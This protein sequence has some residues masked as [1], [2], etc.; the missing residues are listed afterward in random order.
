M[1][2][3]HYIIMLALC[4]LLL[5]GC[6]E[7]RTE[8]VQVIFTPD[9]NSGPFIISTLEI[10]IEA[11]DPSVQLY[12]ILG[13]VEAS[14]NSLMYSG[15]FR[16]AEDT[17]VSVAV[18]K[19]GKKI[20]EAKALYAL[21]TPEAPGETCTASR[22]CSALTEVTITNSDCTTST[23]SCA[24]AEKCT[25]GN[26]NPAT[27][28][29]V[30]PVTC[31]RPYFSL[32]RTTATCTSAG[33]YWYYNACWSTPA[34]GGGGGGGGGSSN[35]APTVT[36]LSP[37]DGQSYKPGN[38]FII[39]ANASDS[40]GSVKRVEFWM[41]YSAGDVVNP[42]TKLGEDSETPYSLVLEN[43]FNQEGNYQL[44][45]I[46]YD[47]KNKQKAT[48]VITIKIT[49]SL[50]ILGALCASGSQCQ[51]GLCVAENDMRARCAAECS[52]LGT[53]CSNDDKAYNN[54]GICAHM[55]NAV[56]LPYVEC[57]SSNVAHIGSKYESPCLAS[58]TSVGD[59]CDT[60]AAGGFV[61]DGTCQADG[62]CKVNLAP[63]VTLNKPLNGSS[64][65]VNTTINVS[66][67]ANDPDGTISKVEFYIGHT[68]GQ[69]NGGGLITDT[70]YPYEISVT[71]SSVG[72]YTFSAK[73]YDALGA[74]TSSLTSYVT[75]AAVN[76]SVPSVSI[77]SPVEGASF[78]VGSSIPITVSAYD[79]DGT[80][81]WAKVQYLSGSNWVDI[82]I[83]YTNAYTYRF[84]WNNA[85]VGSQAIRAIVSDN[86]QAQS[87]VNRNVNVNPGTNH[88]PN[89]SI[90]SP[91]NNA[92]FSVGQSIT[93]TASATDVDNNLK[94]VTFDYEDRDG[95]RYVIGVDSSSPYS[96]IWNNPL[97]G[98]SGLRATARDTLG[99]S[100]VSG[101]VYVNVNTGNLPPV[102]SI[103][104]PSNGANI[105]EGSDVIIQVSASDANNNLKNV[106]LEYRYGSAV[107]SSM[108]VKSV[109]PYTWQFDD[110]Q[111]GVLSLRAT[112]RDT[113]GL[114]TVSGVV[115]V[116][117]NSGVNNPPTVSIT[118]PASNG[119]SV[120]VGSVLSYAGSISDD[121]P[122]LNV[123]WYIDRI[124]DN[125]AGALIKN[126][127]QA[128][129]PT[130]GSLTMTGVKMNPNN[131]PVNLTVVGATYYLWLRVYDGVNTVEKIRT[132]VLVSSSQTVSL[133]NPLDYSVFDEGYTIPL[134]ATASPTSQLTNIRL[135]VD[136]A[137]K[138]TG[139]SSPHTYSWTPSKGTYLIQ[140]KALF[141]VTE[142]TSDISG[143]VVEA[144]CGNNRCSASE[145]GCN[146]PADCGETCSQIEPG[147]L[148]IES[149]STSDDAI[150]DGNEPIKAVDFD[151][152]TYWSSTT[153]NSITLDLGYSQTVSETNMKF[154]K[155]YAYKVETSN[156]GTSW[157]SAVT[158]NANTGWVKS[159][160]NSRNAR[161]VRVTFTSGGSIILYEAEVWGQDNLN[162][163]E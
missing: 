137:L 81:S 99:L 52:S 59:P 26:C 139:T 34:T 69:S 54:D 151:E 42:E 110:A 117:V 124:G 14:L 19:D 148:F 45:A 93:I 17:T 88:A 152:S 144:V 71:P 95:T 22:V 89:V 47:N 33:G 106:T 31:G 126:T 1:G 97:E 15:P 40:D 58:E 50:L 61:A 27:P 80:I 18:F 24:S 163:A 4:A 100:T 136:G 85:P 20:G 162:T 73:A 127:T 107:W 77:S 142:K 102:V 5:T 12:Y 21:V 149:V 60:N 115:N 161:Y 92:N 122:S 74:N 158:G 128:P 132:F 62:T 138:S 90:T 87:S 111:P 135:F 98:K 84:T 108:G 96:V 76:N 41:K 156:D 64:V 103:T 131:Y 56:Q 143:I 133:T 129:G 121:N 160:F 57:V 32:C 66:A 63:T 9:P 150:Q 105:S 119:S 48:P 11:N 70:S 13:D 39:N 46:A 113:L 29:N 83:N 154:G 82:A 134:T 72:I 30:T 104:S 43:G 109:G 49:N 44:W 3:K 86:R 8:E 130:S 68:T 114:S 120:V 75:V 94:N 116:N 118:S 55:Y 125:Q 23:I 2:W 37:V 7:Q 112:A 6:T 140:A 53:M 123:L 35:K 67:T 78:T 79:S 147:L 25:N 65:T 38:K 10:A 157:S 145:D 36:L 155:N 16:I 91:V 159:T 51:S 153:P 28:I 101:V 146:C 141:G